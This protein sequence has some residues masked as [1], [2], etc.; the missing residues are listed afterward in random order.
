MTY[1]KHLVWLLPVCA[2]IGWIAT[3]TRD[4]SIEDSK[5]AA[6]MMKACVDAGGQWPKNFGPS[7]DCVRPER[8]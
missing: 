7:W 5:N 3:M 4:A 2:T 1:I 6:F 8:P